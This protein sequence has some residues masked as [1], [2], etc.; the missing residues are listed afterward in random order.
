MGEVDLLTRVGLSLFIAV[1]FAAAVLVPLRGNAW[2]E[3][4]V[5]RREA[6]REATA[7][8]RMR[9]LVEHGHA[10]ARTQRAMHN[11]YDF[12]CRYWFADRNP[13][14]ADLANR[15]FGGSPTRFNERRCV[16]CRPFG[17]T[18]GRNLTV[19]AA[20]APAECEPSAPTHFFQG[21]CR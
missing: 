6:R 1:V 9:A 13:S 3:A 17:E 2:R 18:E 12:A 21:V 5:K 14:T 11:D 10:T 16:V 15:E 20:L 8:R 4:A 7:R 19:H